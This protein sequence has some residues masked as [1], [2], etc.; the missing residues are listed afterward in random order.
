V[1]VPDADASF[2]EH[3]CVG[4]PGAAVKQVCSLSGLPRYGFSVW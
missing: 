4:D 2:D 3:A 1:V